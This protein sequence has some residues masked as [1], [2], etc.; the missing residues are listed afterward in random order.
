MMSDRQLAFIRQ[1][2]RQKRIILGLRL[3]IFVL[4]IALWEIST[5][6]EWI[7]SFIFSSPSRI[8]FCFLEMAESHTIF[9]HVGVTLGETFFSFFSC[10]CDR[11][12]SR[13]AAVVER[14]RCQGIGALSCCVKQPSKDSSRPG[15]Y[16]MARQ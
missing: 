14:N 2:A 12:P 9:Y 7:D 8:L 16:R 15:I 10:Y 5:K 6:L 1:A 11:N 13:R 3:L 4:F